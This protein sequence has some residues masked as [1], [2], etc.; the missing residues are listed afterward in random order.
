MGMP[1]SKPSGNQ[2]RRWLLGQDQRAVGFLRCETIGRG[3]SQSGLR[4]LVHRVSCIQPPGTTKL[5]GL[6]RSEG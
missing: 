3:A 1:K 2:L 4:M 6:K 5:V